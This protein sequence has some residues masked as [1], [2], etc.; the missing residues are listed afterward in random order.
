MVC[1][2]L[3]EREKSH[4]GQALN[5]M[6]NFRHCLRTPGALTC[7]Q[8]LALAAAPA[9]LHGLDSGEFSLSLKYGLLCAEG[10]LRG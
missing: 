6:S 8:T 5:E 1:E 10:A 7:L 2:A 9:P 3:S 4:L